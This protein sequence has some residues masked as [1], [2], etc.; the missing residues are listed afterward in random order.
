M[1]K[2]SIP[3]D[4]KTKKPT[5]SSFFLKQVMVA[6]G[7]VFV[8]F[9][10]IHLLGNLKV[11]QGAE[12]FN[13][14]AAWLRE[15]GYPLLPKQGVL[16][17]LRLVLMLGLVLHIWAATTIWI[18]GRRARGKFRRKKMAGFSAQTAR[19]MFP[20]GLVLFIFIVVHLLDLTVGAVLSPATFRHGSA[21]QN[22]VASFQR[23]AMALFYI[24]VM[25]LL[26]L[27]V[28]H[29]WRTIMQDV[30]MTGG[31]SR[32][33]WATVGGLLALAILLGNAAIP[34]LVLSGVIS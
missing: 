1:A 26:A 6:T 7:F 21:Y 22:L 29:G 16:W 32:R 34:A 13:S 33:V 20:T 12:A 8:A 31:R 27:H 14:Y 18:R 10:T 2:Q 15:V 25:A 4:Y 5:P 11:Y 17:A 23:P 24:L 19:A 3:V 9:V 30:G 28:E